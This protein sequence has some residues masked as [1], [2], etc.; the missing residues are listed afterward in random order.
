MAVSGPRHA[1]HTGRLQAGERPMVTPP[2]AQE[3][4]STERIGSLAHCD[5]PTRVWNEAEME[6]DM[7]MHYATMGMRERLDQARLTCLM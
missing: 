6:K 4:G 1:V 7:Q 3:A 2:T 5:E